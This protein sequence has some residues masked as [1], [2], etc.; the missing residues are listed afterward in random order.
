V[1][2]T[3]LLALVKRFLGASIDSSTPIVDAALRSNFGAPGVVLEMGF[4]GGV[5]GF[6]ASSAARND[7][8]AK[9]VYIR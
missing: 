2:A 4:D 9:V 7:D 3:A 6:D 1:R 5:D 8:P